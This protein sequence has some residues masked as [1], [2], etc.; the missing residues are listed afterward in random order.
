MKI[1][2]AIFLLISHLLTGQQ[3]DDLE[4]SSLKRGLQSP[5]LK[6]DISAFQSI[7]GYFY[8][9]TI[10]P[11]VSNIE[12]LSA[13]EFKPEL[14]DSQPFDVII[15]EIMADPSPS[16]SSAASDVYKRQL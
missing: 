8:N 1:F 9:D 16:R 12:V 7:A 2:I 13:N 10:P 4:Y 5:W 15:T 6:W 11:K 14:K 3:T